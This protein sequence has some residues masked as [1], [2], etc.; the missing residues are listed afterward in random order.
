MSSRLAERQ[1]AARDDGQSRTFVMR[2]N[3]ACVASS[4]FVLELRVGRLPL[5]RTQY[6][7]RQLLAAQRLRECVAHFHSSQRLQLEQP[8]EGAFKLFSGE[9]TRRV[10][11][12][13]DR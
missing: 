13:F 5:Q 4:S 10:S 8:V 12:V 1:P 11:P 6:F 9:A 2:C 7:H 3:L